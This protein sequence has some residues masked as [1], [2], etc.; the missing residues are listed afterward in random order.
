MQKNVI[1]LSLIWCHK[2]R[3]TFLRVNGTDFSAGDESYLKVKALPL[4]D[5][6]R[7]SLMR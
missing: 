5:E 1:K 4:S 7:V 6:G 3:N 2:V